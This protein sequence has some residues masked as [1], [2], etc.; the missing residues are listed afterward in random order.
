MCLGMANG[1]GA[2]CKAVASLQE[3]EQS[4]RVRKAEEEAQKARQEA[5]RVKQHFAWLHETVKELG[6][7]NDVLRVALGQRDQELRE[8]RDQVQVYS[9]GLVEAGQREAGWRSAV[10]QA[11]GQEQEQV[12]V[13]EQAA[14]QMEVEYAPL[15]EWAPLSEE[16]VQ[17][18]QYV[19][20]EEFAAVFAAG[21]YAA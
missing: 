16:L 15:V 1:V 12:R 2:R 20:E 14:L 6:R 17:G 11:L 13:Q 5:Q 4:E 7:E 3:E 21:G 8:A 10:E 9:Q 19:A 18:Q